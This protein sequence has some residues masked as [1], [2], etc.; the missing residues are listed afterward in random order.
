MKISPQIC[1]RKAFGV[2]S[3]ML[4]LMM[5]GCSA[6]RGLGHTPA[7]P[8]PI[9]DPAQSEVESA[10]AREAGEL[11]IASAALFDKTPVGTA[12]V[13][14]VARYVNGLGETCTKVELKAQSNKTLAGLCKG[15]DGVWRYVPL[16]N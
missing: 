16:S 2:L 15:K 13:T 3:L 8:I 5:V 6:P 7:A 1:S 4:T 12:Q 9:M 14:A 11:P 10:F